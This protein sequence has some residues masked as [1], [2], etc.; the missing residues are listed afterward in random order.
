[1]PLHACTIVARNYLPHARVLARSF[2]AHN[3]GSRF[4]TLLIDDRPDPSAPAFRF[5]LISGQVHAGIPRIR[6][7]PADPGF[8]MTGLTKESFVYVADVQKIETASVLERLGV[9]PGYVAR[10]VD[11]KMQELRRGRAQ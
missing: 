5:V 2:L 11:A 1:M 10:A 9:L 3:P 4:T 7:M 6:L 8:A